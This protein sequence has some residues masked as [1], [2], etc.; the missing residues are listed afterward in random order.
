MFTV[1][2]WVWFRSCAILALWPYPVGSVFSYHS[3]RHRVLSTNVALPCPWLAASL[4]RC[5]ASPKAI[6]LILHSLGATLGKSAL[7]KNVCV[8]PMLGAVQ[9]VFSWIWF[10][11]SWFL[12]WWIFSC[13]RKSQLIQFDSLTTECLPK[14]LQPWILL[15]MA[16]SF[17]ELILIFE[18][19][20]CS[21]NKPNDIA[22][23]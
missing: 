19:N 13:W 18:E 17:L 9:W 14:A 3:V 6:Y 22:C 4:R 21:G 7:P 1:R 16:S 2:W 11:W 5:P 15:E 23:S 10:I 20:S 12:R 8:V